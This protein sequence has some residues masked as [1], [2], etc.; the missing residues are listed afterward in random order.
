VEA[1]DSPEDAGQAAVTVTVAGVE[2]QSIGWYYKAAVDTVVLE[3]SL[4]KR[5]FDT[6]KAQ[7]ESRA[8]VEGAAGHLDDIVV[9]QRD[10]KGPRSEAL[11]NKSGCRQSTIWLKKL[12][13]RC[14]LVA[15]GGWATAGRGLDGDVHAASTKHR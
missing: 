13:G 14:V 11:Y 10:L 7:S 12:G 5:G 6:F 8:D 15:P 9:E 2:P 1:F 4:L 3:T